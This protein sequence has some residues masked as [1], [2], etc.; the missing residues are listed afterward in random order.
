MNTTTYETDSN[1][2]IAETYYH[3]MLEKNFDAMEKCLQ[4]N[5]HFISPLAEMSGK[6]A[7]VEAAEKLSDRLE[8][9]EIRAK[10]SSGNQ[11]MLAYDFMFPKPIG[12]L[13]AAVLMEFQNKLISKI[14]LFFDGEPFDKSGK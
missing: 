12:K 8:G 7:V 9:I 5:V 3:S 4:P 1:L 6:D 11:I 10:F 2:I 13:R 14:E